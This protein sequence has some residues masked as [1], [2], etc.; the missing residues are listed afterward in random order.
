M[1]TTATEC[2]MWYAL[3]GGAFISLIKANAIYT[4][5]DDD[6]VDVLRHC[7]TNVHRFFLF[8]TKRPTSSWRIHIAH[9]LENCAHLCESIYSM[10]VMELWQHSV[11]S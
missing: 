10:D 7:Y 2:S 6:V 1:K 8:F 4:K 9:S 3:F 11:G 5:D